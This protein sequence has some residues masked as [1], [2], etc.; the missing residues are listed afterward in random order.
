M[1]KNETTYIDIYK[2]WLILK[3]YNQ[4]KYYYIS[5]NLIP[6]NLTASFRIISLLDNLWECCIRWKDNFWRESL[7][8]GKGQYRW[9]PCTC[10]FRLAAFK[11]KIFIF[12]FYTTSYL[13]K[14]VNCFGISLITLFLLPIWVCWWLK[15]KL[16]LYDQKWNIYKW[17]II[18]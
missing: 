5:V 9:P 3:S 18:L 4:K 16:F 2:W 10:Q 6:I 14:E 13:N 1:E 7:L 15:I 11:T 17:S 8:K 12:L